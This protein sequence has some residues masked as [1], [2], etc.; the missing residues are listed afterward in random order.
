MEKSEH[1]EFV[2][3]NL[4]FFAKSREIVGQKSI[5]FEL[6]KITTRNLIIDSITKKFPDLQQIS[7]NI[8][9]SLNEEY[10]DQD[11][12]VTLKAGDELAVIPPLSGG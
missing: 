7:K 10:L 12:S 9:L 3:V 11:C 4:L 5:L 6:P 2:E 8:L 1:R